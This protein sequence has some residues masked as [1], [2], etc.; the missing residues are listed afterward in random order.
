MR[1]VE[2]VDTMKK[3]LESALRNQRLTDL[4]NRIRDNKRTI[5]NLISENIFV[6]KNG[7]QE[8]DKH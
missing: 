2:E 6:L 3:Y 1:L 8:N 5:V 4:E 7:S